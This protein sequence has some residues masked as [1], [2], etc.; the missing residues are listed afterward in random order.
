M[1]FK[2]VTYFKHPPW[3]FANLLNVY[4]IRQN[5]KVILIF[6]RIFQRMFPYFICPCILV[7]KLNVTLQYYSD[8][9]SMSSV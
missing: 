3:N 9:I 7:K 8:T 4:E 2:D 1:I 6:H 5:I